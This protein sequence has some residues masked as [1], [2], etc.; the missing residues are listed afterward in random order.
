MLRCEGTA[1]AVLCTACGLPKRRSRIEALLLEASDPASNVRQG[2]HGCSY[3]RRSATPRV[4]FLLFCDGCVA[5]PLQRP[6][7]FWAQL[8]SSSSIV[9][10][11]EGPSGIF[12]R[13]Y[14]LLVLHV[15]SLSP[16][17]CGSCRLLRPEL[18]VQPSTSDL[19]RSNLM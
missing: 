16:L 7:T 2:F 18:P 11:Q 17:R 9:S 12:T 15:F 5:Q 10:V 19:N 6:R 1:V 14:A 13:V 3:L 8:P 4:A